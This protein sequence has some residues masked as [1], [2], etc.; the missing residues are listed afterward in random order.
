VTP[1]SEAGPY[2]FTPGEVCKTLVMAYAELVQPGA[3]RKTA[4]AE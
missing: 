2:R 1:V 4:A 3:A